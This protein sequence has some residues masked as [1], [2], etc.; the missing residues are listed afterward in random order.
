MRITRTETTIRGT[1]MMTVM[2]TIILGIIPRQDT[3][4]T[5][6]SLTTVTV[7]SSCPRWGLH[8]SIFTT[9]MLIA[10]NTTFDVDDNDNDN[11]NGNV[12]SK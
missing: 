11:D 3:I 1:M 8:Q 9:T 7:L 12:R 5:T 2:T 6:T 10:L 4:A